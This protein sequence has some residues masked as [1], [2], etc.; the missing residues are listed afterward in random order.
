MCD[1]ILTVLVLLLIGA[2]ALAVQPY[3]PVHPDPM[4][5]PWRWTVFPEL[6]GL[7]NQNMVHPPVA[8]AWFLQSLTHRIVK[9]RS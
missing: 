6:R 1:L 2:P 4:L 5:E 7:G 9:L 3:T 8:F